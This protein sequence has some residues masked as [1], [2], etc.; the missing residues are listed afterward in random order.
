MPEDNSDKPDMV[1]HPAHYNN[2]PSGVE[3]IDIIEHMP[4]NVASAMKYLW[5]CDEKHL[6]PFE[7]LDKALWY[8]KREITRRKKLCQT[9]QS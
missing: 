6:D 5:R 3:C 4:S 2:H 7:D 8:V 1:D 9:A